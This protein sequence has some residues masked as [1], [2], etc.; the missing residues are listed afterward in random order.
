[1]GACGGRTLRLSALTFLAGLELRLQGDFG[2]SFDQ[3]RGSNES[4]QTT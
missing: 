1:M 3:D 4:T 2:Y